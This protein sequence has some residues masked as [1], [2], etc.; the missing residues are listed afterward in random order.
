MLLLD[1]VLI[2]FGRLVAEF[3]AT[4]FGFELPKQFSS[5]LWIAVGLIFLA[6]IIVAVVTMPRSKKKVGEFQERKAIKGLRPFTKEDAAVFAR[7]QRQRML[8]ECLEALMNSHFRFGV[9]Y[10]ESGCG[11]TSFLQAG[12]WHHLSQENS[13]ELGIYIRI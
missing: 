5:W 4:L 1:A 13:K 11:K 3:L 8:K 12:L 9:L 2:L 10:G 7:L 6:A